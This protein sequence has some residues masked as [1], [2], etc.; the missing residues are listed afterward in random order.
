MRS[1]TCVLVHLVQSTPLSDS[2]ILESA[3]SAL[4]NVAV[5]TKWHKEIGGALF[6][7]Y[8]LLDD[9]Q[10]GNE[11]VIVQSLRLLINLSCNDDMITS[12][13]AVQVRSTILVVRLEC[14]F[15][16]ILLGLM[17]LC[18]ALGSN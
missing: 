12:L 11:E 3:L 2:P 8:N 13:L 6:R 9:C 1:V 10:W 16:S 5:L 7:L 18:F 14:V 17:F 4:T 15:S